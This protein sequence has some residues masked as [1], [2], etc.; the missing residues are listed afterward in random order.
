MRKAT[1]QH[2]KENARRKANRFNRAL[3]QQRKRQGHKGHFKGNRNPIQYDPKNLQI[4]TPTNKRR[5]LEGAKS[6]SILN[7][8]KWMVAIRS[9]KGNPRST[10]SRKERDRVSRTQIHP[11]AQRPNHHGSQDQRDAVQ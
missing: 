3:S 11:E 9:S 7:S 10:T 4:Q 5:N 6:N 8:S 2:R 1:E